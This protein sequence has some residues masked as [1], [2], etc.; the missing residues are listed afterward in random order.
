MVS[1]V[2]HVLF[3]QVLIF[4]ILKDGCRSRHH[5]ACV[6]YFSSIFDGHCHTEANISFEAFSN[7]C[8]V[9]FFV[10]TQARREASKSY[11]NEREQRSYV[12]NCCDWSSAGDELEAIMSEYVLLE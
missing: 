2:S 6:L 1:V 9:D 11:N 8:V 4:K 12:M 3:H 7:Q 10:M 5:L